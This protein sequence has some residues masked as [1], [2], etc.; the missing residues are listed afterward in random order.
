MP[1]FPPGLA[2]KGL[3][4]IKP[5][6]DTGKD[7]RE[8]QPGLA[9]RGHLAFSLQVVSDCHTQENHRQCHKYGAEKWQTLHG[10]SRSAIPIQQFLR[11]KS[12]RAEPLQRVG[13]L[14]SWGLMVR[15][16]KDRRV[17]NSYPWL[18]KICCCRNP[19]A[20]TSKSSC[21][22]WLI[23]SSNAAAACWGSQWILKT[24]GSHS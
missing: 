3:H 8:P 20:R 1:P 11:R 15:V 24:C 4:D 14:L 23:T 2:E 5:Y 13:K 7:K 10:C 16:S 18:R 22:G 9:R 12:R 6:S 19:G 17:I 21:P